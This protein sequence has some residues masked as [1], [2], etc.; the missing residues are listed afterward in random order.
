MKRLLSGLA[1]IM[2]VL[3][4]QAQTRD[5]SQYYQNLPTEVA[6]VSAPQIPANEISITEVGGVGDGVTL[7]TKAFED[8]IKKL[9]KMPGAGGRLNV[10]QG[11]WLTGPIQLKDN[12]ELHLE[13]NAIILM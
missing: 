4:A 12:I 1:A 2:L 3:S 6:Q 5:Y 11:V 8:G 9:Q 13:K 7:N 10:P